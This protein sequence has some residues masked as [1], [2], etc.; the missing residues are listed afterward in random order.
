MMC[1]N[2]GNEV[3]DNFCS[4]CGQRTS[5][6][7]ITLR[8]GWND[9]WSRVYGFD[10]MLPRTLRD[11]TLR[12]GVVAQKYIDCNRVLYYGPVGY[13][14]LMLTLYLL[15]IG[16]IG[17]DIKEMLAQNQQMLAPVEPG[18]GQQKFS[19]LVLEWVSNNMKLMLPLHIIFSFVRVN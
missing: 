18:Q 5:V 1:V 15:M 16:M 4:H 13:F 2:C 3:T 7:R 17:V 8:E 14:F 6:K 19:Q 9:F 11:L 10:G 12:P